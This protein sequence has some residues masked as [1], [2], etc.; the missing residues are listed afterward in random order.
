MVLK[1]GL[2]V[3]DGVAE[4]GIRNSSLLNFLHLLKL[5][6]GDDPPRYLQSHPLLALFPIFLASLKFRVF[7]RDS[8][9]LNI[10]LSKEIR[11]YFLGDWILGLICLVGLRE[12]WVGLSRLIHSHLAIPLNFL[13][14][15]RVPFPSLNFLFLG[16]LAKSAIFK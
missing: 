1:T 12:L 6:S 11:I 2:S 4:G 8:F 13:S 10:L 5:Y 16:I 3:L 14:H 15:S 9:V 7:N